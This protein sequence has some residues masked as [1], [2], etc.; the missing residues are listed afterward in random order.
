MAERK[1]RAVLRRVSTK[2]T[3]P[4]TTKAVA[5]PTK[6]VARKPKAVTVS[7]KGSTKKVSK[8]SLQKSSTAA[9][10]ISKKATQDSAEKIDIKIK[11]NKFLSGK[12]APSKKTEK[13]A[14]NNKKVKEAVSLATD[15]QVAIHDDSIT[16]FSRVR[17]ANTIMLVARVLGIAFVVVGAFFTLI[18]ISSTN[19]TGYLSETLKKLDSNFVA[20]LT[21]SIAPN[22]TD[23][24]I[25]ADTSG[26]PQEPQ[27]RIDLPSE[28]VSGIFELNFN[29]T[30][31]SKVF[32]RLH[33]KD[34]GAVFNLGDAKTTDGTL[35]K[36]R[37]DT[38][39]FKDGEY[40][41]S[42]HATDSTG[43]YIKTSSDKL[44][45]KN[46]MAEL[47][48]E[49]HVTTSE[50]TSSSSS[51]TDLNSNSD[52]DLHV[53]DEE[54][55][56]S[57][58][59]TETSVFTKTATAT[60]DFSQSTSRI[61]TNFASAV[62]GFVTVTALSSGAQFAEFYVRQ[63]DSLR[64]IFIGLGRESAPG[65]WKLYWDT[66]QV[67]NAEYKIFTKHKNSFGF[68]WSDF[69]SVVVKN[70]LVLEPTEIEKQII[71]T[72]NEANENVVNPLT[73]FN[74]ELN[75]ELDIDKA[76]TSVA[77]LEKEIVAPD[78]AVVLRDHQ[79]AIEKAVQAYTLALR[80][81]DKARRSVTLSNLDE[82][83]EK[84]IFNSIGN[85]N[86]TDHTAFEK[87]IETRFK[88]LVAD[89]ENSEDLIR[90][91][92]GEVITL[93]SDLDG[94]ID[95][96]ELTLYKTNPFS[97]D[98]DGDGFTDE[99]ELL[100]GFDPNS[101]VQESAIV[102]ESPK[103]SGI[104]REDVFVVENIITES[105]EVA[106]K[107]GENPVAI[108]SGRALPNSFVTIYIFSTP[109]IITVKTSE[110]G[111]WNYR[112]DKELEDGEHQVFVGVTDNAGKI[113][114]KSNP[115]TFVKEAE[116]FSPVGAETNAGIINSEPSQPSLLN[117][118]TLLVA[119]GSVVMALGFILLLMTLYLHQRREEDMSLAHAQ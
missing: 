92:I 106:I 109:I 79:S 75:G 69:E 64:D 53:V 7:K 108:I 74:N 45:I 115:F 68:Y 89:V 43:A 67:P 116:A 8:K 29:I 14:N 46:T 80:A 107:G 19:E 113:V 33:S 100:G 28:A 63:K 84:I 57:E 118:S 72:I 95:Y 93:D 42:V 51:V 15:H 119:A 76:T 58:S 27:I 86:V 16:I 6:K 36:Y 31:A 99:A 2:K 39:K 40:L 47:P 105:S 111:S 54:V 26:A 94:I 104:V 49:N 9:G 25:V 21:T 98:S 103:E 56:E 77:V 81:D 87:A 96:D 62:S 22:T 112:F 60:N 117:K 73:V 18:G 1:T 70:N 110:D 83:K 11:T 23:T 50:D 24:A 71:D 55:L 20:N 88:R 52:T 5:G 12:A 41:V 91:R 61:S 101:D 10:K 30:F 48:A 78:L 17:T 44:F 38:T 82:L 97:A 13:V 4:N 90:E 37:L 66:K 59:S 32:V 85:Q 102:F 35:W 114:A 65:V 3:T 34:T